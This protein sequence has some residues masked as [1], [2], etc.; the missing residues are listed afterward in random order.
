[1]QAPS[2]ID[3]KLVS[4]S[5]PKYSRIRERRKEWGRVF[6]CGRLR[7]RTREVE[8]S[9]KRRGT[10]RRRASSDRALKG[11]TPHAPNS[12]QQPESCCCYCCF[13]TSISLFH[14]LSLSLSCSLFISLLSSLFGYN[15]LP[16]SSFLSSLYLLQLR[17]SPHPRFC[18]LF[19]FFVIIIIIVVVICIHKRN[20]A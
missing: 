10:L 7:E 18:L 6:S 14:S 19:F 12:C 2:R 13:S 5:N 11:S 8:G 1:M 4:I 20:T 9:G 17:P 3:C 16:S 15:R